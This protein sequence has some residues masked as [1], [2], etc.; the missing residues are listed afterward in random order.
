MDAL[1]QARPVTVPATSLGSS[2][3]VITSSCRLCGWSLAAQDVTDPANTGSFTSPGAG[4]VIATMTLAQGEYDLE[5]IVA[6][7]GTTSASEVNNFG[8]NVGAA[9]VAVSVNGSSSGSSYTQDTVTIRVPAGGATVTITAIGAGTAASVYRAQMVA[10][11]H[12]PAQGVFTDGA[13]IVG[14]FGIAAGLAETKWLGGD[15]VYIGTQLNMQVNSG[16]VSG[17]VY[18]RDRIEKT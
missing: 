14:V 11:G 4:Q 5:W 18:I 17:V 12:I 6:L 2:V 1:G 13:Q 8:L 15:G 10:G 16:T 3:P 7:G 9:Q